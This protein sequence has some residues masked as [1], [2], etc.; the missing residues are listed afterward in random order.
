MTKIITP[1]LS[2]RIGEN[3]RLELAI[4]EKEEEVAKE[5]LEFRDA[6]TGDIL[7]VLE[8]T[9]GD[10]LAL[11]KRL[12]E[13]ARHISEDLES[14]TESRCSVEQYLNQLQAGE[15]SIEEALLSIRSELEAISSL[16]EEINVSNEDIQKLR[17]NAEMIGDAV[18][19]LRLDVIALQKAAGV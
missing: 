18:K 2:L 14:L 13:T 8:A 19:E 16:T 1:I 3:R 10:N 6:N 5:S 7:K 12:I 11:Q 9:M 15:I 17:G 4:T